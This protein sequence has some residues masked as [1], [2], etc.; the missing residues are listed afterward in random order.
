[1]RSA[2]RL[3]SATFPQGPANGIRS[4]HRLFSFIS[5]NWRARPLLSYRVI[6]NL[7]SATTTQTG[8]SVHCELDRKRYP[9]GVKVSD[10]EKAAIKLKQA[11]FHGDW[12]YTIRP[13]N[14]QNRSL[15]T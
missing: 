2:L 5:Q 15:N 10:E 4:K 7:I 8:L 12:N 13:N 1:M 14:C 3:P 9:K 11:A 6:V